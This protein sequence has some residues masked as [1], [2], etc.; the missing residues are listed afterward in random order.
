MWLIVHL[1]ALGGM[2]LSFEVQSLAAFLICFVM[3][4]QLPSYRRR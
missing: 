3:F 1:C 2:I 4:C